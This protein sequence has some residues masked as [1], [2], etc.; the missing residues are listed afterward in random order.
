MRLGLRLCRAGCAAWRRPVAGAA[1]G[2]L[3]AA[4]SGRRSA[5]HA[6]MVNTLAATIQLSATERELFALL[7]QV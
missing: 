7:K 2:R 5:A 3:Q 1:S 4:S 6:T